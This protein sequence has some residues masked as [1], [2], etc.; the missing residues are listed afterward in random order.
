MRLGLEWRHLNPVVNGAF[1]WPLGWCNGKVK[2]F[3]MVATSR[4]IARCCADQAPKISRPTATGSSKR[5]RGILN[6]N[7]Y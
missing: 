6:N 7:S 4:P 3:N 1:T 2:Q 5:I